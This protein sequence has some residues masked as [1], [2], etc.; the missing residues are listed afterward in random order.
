M[1]S[2]V[3]KTF[4]RMNSTRQ[5]QRKEQSILFQRLPVSVFGM[6]DMLVC[7]LETDM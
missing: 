7:M 2:P 4:E 1:N 5:R 3:M 6:M